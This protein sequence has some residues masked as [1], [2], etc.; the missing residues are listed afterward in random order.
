MS[1]RTTF[2]LLVNE[3][4]ELL[5]WEL[6]NVRFALRNLSFDH[7]ETSKQWRKFAVKENR[8]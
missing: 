4:V 2:L 8:V 1:E 7:N 3:K 6:L 5:V